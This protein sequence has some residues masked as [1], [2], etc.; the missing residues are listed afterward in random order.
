MA[1]RTAKHKV[2]RE[3]PGAY[4]KRGKT[5]SGN[6]RYRLI[7]DRRVVASASSARQLWKNVWRALRAEAMVAPC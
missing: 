4:V 5:R 7:W 1:K 3:L 6:A 2:L